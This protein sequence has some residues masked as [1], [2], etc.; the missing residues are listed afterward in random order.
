VVGGWNGNDTTPVPARPARQHR[1]PERGQRG[2]GGDGRA[3]RRRRRR[4]G[5]L[6]RDRHRQRLERQQQPAHQRGNG[7]AAGRAG[8]VDISGG[9]ARRRI[10]VLF[11]TSA[12]HFNQQR[13]RTGGNA[14]RGRHRDGRRHRRH[15][16]CG[17]A[18]IEARASPSPT[19]HDQGRHE[20][21]MA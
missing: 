8:G 13:Q 5:R 7:G 9:V 12:A 17:G 3:A 1:I 4:R 18:G 6:W 16:R 11:T 14:G 21:L 2:K 15:E 10:G 19:R 20:R